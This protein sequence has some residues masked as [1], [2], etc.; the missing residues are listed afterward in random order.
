MGSC[1]GGRRTGGGGAGGD[2]SNEFSQQTRS[3]IGAYI[4][5]Q[6]G[7]DISKYQDDFT[8]RYDSPG[9]ETVY[10]KDMP[11]EQRSRLFQFQDQRERVFGIIDIGAWGVQILTGDAK[12][13]H[14]SA[15][16]SRWG[17]GK[18][19]TTSGWR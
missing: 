15:M 12:K 6:I 14:D 17:K 19:R 5:K 1:S 13:R 16:D 9:V 2:L 3:E 8:R 11:R 18:W 10:I 7:V 4:K